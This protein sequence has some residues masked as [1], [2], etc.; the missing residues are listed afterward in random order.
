[1]AVN[2]GWSKRKKTA[3]CL[4]VS[5]LRGSE[6]NKTKEPRACRTCVLSCLV[7]KPCFALAN[8]FCGDTCEQRELSHQSLFDFSLGDTRL[9]RNDGGVSPVVE[10]R[11]TDPGNYCTYNKLLV[12]QSLALFCLQKAACHTHLTS[13]YK[14]TC[15]FQR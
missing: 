5:A 2:D 3:A 1:M 13:H 15:W 6:L 4:I 10:G 11:E 12:R 7:L 8:V 9:G 14:P